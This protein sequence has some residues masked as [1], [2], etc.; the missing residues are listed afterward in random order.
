MKVKQP[1]MSV[2]IK[3]PT[4]IEL[5]RI[6]FENP[7]SIELLKN[8]IEETQKIADKLSKSKESIQLFLESQ[9]INNEVID[10]KLLALSTKIEQLRKSVQDFKHVIEAYAND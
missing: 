7:T 3:N 5:L 6:K 8:E 4:G 1:H 10:E 9:N 2:K